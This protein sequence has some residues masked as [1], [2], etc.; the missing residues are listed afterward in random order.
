MS[1]KWWLIK[2]NNKITWSSAWGDKSC[3]WIPSMSWYISVLS[4]HMLFLWFAFR[5]LD[6]FK[7]KSSTKN[8]NFLAALTE[9]HEKFIRFLNSEFNADFKKIIY[10]VSWTEFECEIIFLAMLTVLLSTHVL[11][12]SNLWIK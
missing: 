4:R 12:Y 3:V 8:L 10:F 6:F 7:F 1:K 9:I 11:L 5:L 2:V